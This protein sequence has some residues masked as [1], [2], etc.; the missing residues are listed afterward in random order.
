MRCRPVGPGVDGER[1]ISVPIWLICRS[2]PADRF[3]ARRTKPGFPAVAINHAAD[4]FFRFAAAD[5]WRAA[6]ADER[7]PYAQCSRARGAPRRRQDHAGPAR[8]RPRAL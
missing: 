5:R 3:T 7:A 6:R 8:A 2:I 4:A 1:A